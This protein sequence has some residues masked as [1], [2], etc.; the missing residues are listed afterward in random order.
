MKSLLP[1][2]Y[3]WAGLRRDLVAGVTVAAIA[4][5]QAMA[6][7]LIAGIHPRYGLYT[8]VIMTALGSIFGSSSHLINGPTNA[9]S[10]VVF[11]ALANIDPDARQQ[12]YEATF[13]LAL[14]VG[15]VQVGIALFKL[16]DLTRFISESVVLGFMAGAGVLVALSQV[17][18]LFGLEDRG[19]GHQHLLVR[20]WLTLSDG[21][22]INPHALGIGLAT[23]VLVVLLRRVARKY[24]LPRADMLLV[25]VAAAAVVAACGW[26]QPG[27]DGKATVAV[28]GAV[29]A[30]LP[31][32]HL[33]QA[34]FR[35]LR[36]MAG[37]ALAIALL[38]LLEA[39][40]IA[41]SIA[42]RTREPLDY[43]R[44]C[45]AEGLANLGGGLFQCMPGSG[46]LTRSAINFQAGAVSRLSGILAAAAVALTLLLLAPLARYVPKPALAGL[47]LV[48]AAGLIDWQRLRYALRAT[49]YDAGLVLATACA[50]VFISIEFSILIGTFL[51]FLFFVPRAARL[52]AH[53][54][55]VSAERVVRERQP[56]DPRCGKLVVLD[57]EGELF[58]GSAP[59][60]EGYFDDLRRRVTEGVRVV[61]LRV[62]RTRNPDMVCLERLQHF[63]EEMHARKVTA[64]LCGVRDD[65]AQGL[66][67]LRF[68]HWLPAACIFLEDAAAG[69]STLKA[70]RYA[71]ELLG[72]DLCPTCP[73][74]NEREP[75][76]GEWYYMI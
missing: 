25:L 55:V 63:L 40:A 20:L 64:L 43:N 11:S 57:L 72:A 2:G 70:V 19:T 12:A 60:L 52:S 34:E 35:W 67:N 22:P 66:R 62:K 42:S 26:N 38:G 53:E 33:P 39:V 23:T 68:H 14:M 48:T 58:F 50:A 13:F 51:S 76:R 17:S 24:H 7:A 44:Q 10:L 61:I 75:D 15:A 65:F 41:K 47:L 49:R 6:Y 46:S 59:E 4:V 69:S 29:P 73:R 71:Y 74:R 36:E 18:N 3:G 9:I 5:P 54:L 28:I 8:A 30:G 21:G 16:G 45:L 27:P 1:A 31:A 32:F 37:S 56:D